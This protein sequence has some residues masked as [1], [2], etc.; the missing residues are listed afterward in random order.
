MNA[1]TDSESR[2]LA[3][4]DIIDFKWLLTAEGLHVHVER[5]Q[6]DPDYARHC[7]DKADA[8]SREAVRDAAARLRRRLGLA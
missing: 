5:L 7:L 4:A 8:S 2:A 6:S 1:T 3:L